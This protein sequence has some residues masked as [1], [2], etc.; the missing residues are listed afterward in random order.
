MILFMSFTQFIQAQSE[1]LKMTNGTSQVP[2]N[3]Y[4]FY[5]SGG[6]LLFTPGT[7]EADEYNWTT[8]YQHNED[9]TLT[10]TVP[11]GK[12]VKVEFSK[13][14]INND[15]LYFYEG[16]VVDEANLICI[17]TCNDYSSSLDDFS[18]ISHGNMTIRFQSDYHW[19]D[20]G[21]VATIK[22]TDEFVSQAPVAVMA[23]CANQMV[24]IPTCNADDGGTMPM[25]YKLNG[26]PWQDY[27]TTGAWVDLTGQT[28]PLTVKTRTKIDEENFSDENT[29]TFNAITAPGNPTYTHNASSNTVTTYF[30][31]KPD[32]V[33]D[34]YYVRWTINNNSNSSHTE[35]PNLWEQVGHE[36]QQP[37]NTPNTVPAGD[38]DYTNVELSLPFYIHFA[39][40]GTT[41]PENFSGVVTVRI[42]ERYVPKPTISFENSGSYGVA[43]LSCSLTDATIYYTTD[44][45]T[46][47]SSST[48][49]TS[50]FNVLPGTTVNA[51][52][53]RAG[54][55]P[56]VVASAIFIPGGEGS[57]GNG[58]Y[59]QVVLLDDRE[60]HSWSYYSDG[61]QPI[62]SLNPTD[63]KI[64]YFGDG[65]GTMTNASENQAN[66]TTFSANATGAMVNYDALANQFVYLKTLENA[67]AEGTGNYPYTMIPNP[68]QIRP[69]FN[70]KDDMGGRGQGNPQRGNRDVDIEDFEGCAVGAIPDGWCN[71]CVA[72]P[73]GQNVTANPTVS[74]GITYQNGWQTVTF[75]MGNNNKFMLLQAQ[76]GNNNNYGNAFIV[77][78][79][80]SEV[81]AIEFDYRCN[82]NQ[83]NNIRVG[84]YR[85]NEAYSDANEVHV[86]SNNDNV[87]HFSL[88]STNYPALFEII[89]NGGRIDFRLFNSGT[90]MMYAGIDNVTV[91]YVGNTPPANP[92][93]DYANGHLFEGT[94]AAITVTDQTSNVTIYYTLDGTTPNASS[95]TVTNGGTVTVDIT[96]PTLK[97]IAIRN[98]NP[99]LVSGVTTATY[100]FNLRT[101]TF[102]PDGGVIVGA[103]SQTVTITRLDDNT[104]VYYTLD[105]TD[106]TTSSPHFTSE[107]TT[108]TVD[109]SHTVLK[110]IAIHN[111]NN[112]LTSA[113]KT[114]VYS[115]KLNDPVISPNSGFYFASQTVTITQQGEGD[116]YYTTDGSVPDPTHVGGSYPTQPYTGAFTV[117]TTTT[118]KAIAY[119]DYGSSDVVEAVIAIGQTVSNNNQYRG[120][121]AWRVKR[122][123]EGLR[124]QRADGTE[125]GVGGII[126]AEDPIEFITSKEEGNEVDFEA[127]WAQAYVSVAGNGATNI[128]SQN[129]GFERNFVVLNSNSN[130]YYGGNTNPR[131]N[132]SDYAATISNYYPNGAPGNTNAGMRG[133]ITLAA[134]VK[135]ENTN[136]SCGTIT[137]NNHYLCFGRGISTNNMAAG[138]V[139]GVTLGSNTYGDLNYT[140]RMET[141][142][143][144]K[145]AFIV[146]GR[147]DNSG[148]ATFSYARGRVQVKS[149]LGSDYDRAQGDNT[150]LEVS[151]N[152]TLY[153]SRFVEITS[154]SNKDAKT[155]DCVVKSG[156]YQRDYWQG[157]NADGNSD[158]NFYC[159][160]NN[161][162]DNTYPGVRYITV[163]GGE[164]ASMNGGQGTNDNSLDNATNHASTDVVCLNVRIK[165]G[166]FNGSVFGG[167]SDNISNGG[168]S[169]VITGGT[170]KGWVAG[171]ANGTGTAANTSSMAI[172][173]GDSYIYVGGNALIG[174]TGN[175]AMVV[176]HTLG[177]Q[178]FGAG[179]GAKNGDG[180]WQRASVF[181][182]NV[183]IADNAT[184]SS[185]TQANGGSVY[186][187]GSLGVVTETANVY[188]LG[189]TIQN[190]VFGGAYG[191]GITNTAIPTS[192]IY[193]RGNNTIINGS[194][195]GGSN[196]CG[197]V[198][199]THVTMTGG[200]TTNV[201]GGGFGS[202]GTITV[203][204]GTGGTNTQNN[205][206]HNG[207]NI[208]NSTTVTVSGGTINNVYGGGEEGTVTGN[209][210]VTYSGGAVKNVYG[211]GKG[212]SSSTAQVTG[213]TYTTVN[214]GTVSECVYGGGEAGDVNNGLGNLAS[215]V[216]INGGTV[217]EDVFG[218]G[219]MG[220]TTGNVIVNVFNGNIDGNVFGGAYG[221]RE[222]V[223]IAGTHTVNMTGGNVYTNV[224]GGSRNADDALTFNPSSNQTATVNV[225]NISG[226]HVYYQVFAG[227]FFGQNYGSVYAFIGQNAIYNA[228]N[229]APTNG[230]SYNVTA[231]LIDGSVWAGADFGAFD[232]T[233]FG[234]P[235]VEGNSNVYIDGLGYNTVS[236]KPSD[237]GY[238]NI[239]TSVLGCGTSCYAGKLRNDLIFRNYGQ[240]VDNPNY[241]SESTT[242][243]YTTA[244]RNLKSIQFFKDAVIE[245][246]H[247]HFIGQGR[248]NSLLTTEKYA[249]YEISEV[250]HV[251]NGSSI[252]TD[253]PID[254]LMKLGS[255]TCPDVYVASPT[256]TKVNYNQLDPSD[257]SND[258]KFRINN[259]SLI[260]VKYTDGYGMGMPYGEFEG[261]FFVMTDDNNSVCAYARPKQ[262]TDSGNEI[263]PDYDNPDDG[264][265]LS[266]HTDKNIYDVDGGTDGE[267]IQMPYENHTL[268]SG[269]KNGEQYFR[270]WRYGGMYSYRQGVI[271]AVAKPTAGYSTSD[272]IINLPASRGTGSYFR[273]KTK[274]GGFPLIDYGSDVITVNAGVSNSSGGIGGTP[275]ANGWMYYDGDDF[276]EGQT[277]GQTNVDAGLTI[278]NANVNANF[279]LVAIP[280]GSLVGTDNGNWLICTDASDSGEAL[281][282]S[283]WSNYNETINPSILFRLT[284]NNQLTN[285]AVWDPIVI[286]L[287]QCNS[288]GTVTDE[289]EV[290]LSIS[291]TTTIEQDF[292]A[293]TFAFMDGGGTQAD[294]YVAKVV[295]PSYYQY[296]NVPGDLSDW[297]FVSAAWTPASSEFTNAWKVGSGYV[298]NPPYANNMFSMQIQPS[299]NFD[300]T[301]GWT[302]FDHTAYD[303]QTLQNNNQHPL[304]SST[305]GRNASAFD[306][307]L[308]FDGRAECNDEMLMGTL[309]VTLHLTNYKGSD[310]VNNEK[311][312]I[313]DVEVWRRGIRNIYFL[314]G[315]NGNNYFR[316]TEPNT[317]K[318]TLNGIFNHSNYK[319]GD[320]IFVV[321]TVTANGLDW[322]GELY[323][324][325]IIYRYPG[326]HPKYNSILPTEVYLDYDEYNPGNVGFTGPLLNVESSMTMHGIILDGS[327]DIAVGHPNITLVPE[328]NTY[329]VPTSPLVNIAEDATLTVYANSELRWNYSNCDGGAIYN[330][331]T[332]IINNG[333]S[334]HNNAVVSNSYNGA[335]V[336]L[337]EGATLM[338]SDLVTIN[339]NHVVVSGNDKN[340]NV[341]L[342]SESSV[343]QIGTID[344]ND[345]YG[346]LESE[347]RIGVTKG[348]WGRYYYTPIAYSDGGSDYLNNLIPADEEAP[349]G[350]YLIFDDGLYYHLVTLN[351]TETY[352]PSYNYLFWVGTWVTAVHERPS[353][354]VPGSTVNITNAEDLAWAISVV[355]GLNNQTATPNTN[356]VITDDIDMAANIWVPI[357]TNANPYTGT[358][359]AQGHNITGIHSPLN[360]ENMGVFGIVG[361]NSTVENMVVEVDFSGGSSVNMG[362]VA[363][364]VD[365][366]GSTITNVEAAGNITGSTTTEAIGGIVAVVNPSTDDENPHTIGNVFSVATM[367]ATN[368]ET[369]IGGLVGDNAADLINSYA[370]AT[371]SGSNH[372][373]GL[374]SQNKGHIENCYSVIGEQTFPAFADVNVKNE[375]FTGVIKICYTDNPYEG[376][377]VNDN[378]T[379]AV[380]EGH[381]T[382]DLI[383]ERKAY[384]Y[385]YDDNAITLESGETS[386]YIHNATIDYTDDHLINWNGLL[387]SL[388][389]WVKT[390]PD[391]SGCTPWFR[392]TSK[393]INGD[394]PILAFPS[395]NCLGTLDNDGKFLHYGSIANEANGLD[396]LLY[397]FNE[398]MNDDDASLFLYGNAT[399]VTRVPESQVKMFIN[400]DACLLQADGAGDFINTTVGI[401]FDN[402]YKAATTSNQLE[403]NQTLTYDWHFLSSPLADASIGIKYNDEAQNWWQ[404]N[405][406]TQ[407]IEVT[408]SYF[409]DGIDT[410]TV[411]LPDTTVLLGWDIYTFYEP[412]YHWINLKRNSSSHYHF[413]EPHEY[414]DYKNETIFEPGKGYMMAIETDS[415]LSNTGTLNNGNADITIP[416]TYQSHEPGITELGYNL[417]GNP[418]QAYLDMNEFLDEN[419]DLLGS[420]FWVYVA[421]NNNYVGTSSKASENKALPTST[422]HPHQAFFV[423]TNADDTATFNYKKMATVKAQPNS[424]FRGRIN[425]PLVNLFVTNEKGQKDLAVIEVNRPELGGTP[426]MRTLNNANFEFY[427]RTNGQDYSILFT[428]EGTERVAMGFKAK[429]DGTYTLTWDTQNGEFSYLQL[430]DNITGNQC[431]MLASDHYSFE[432][433]VTDLATRFYVVFKVDNNDDD[434]DDTFAFFNGNEWIINGKGTLQLIDVTGR[435]I[436]SEYLPGETS[437]RIHFDNFADGVYVL[438]LGDKTQ[439]IVIK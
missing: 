349:A 15:F 125:V 164:F 415:Y 108:V 165:D 151:T 362:G 290:A 338:V 6:P 28:F 14:L 303:L 395:D 431:D 94:S 207:T 138:I 241:S 288:D 286:I 83:Y 422:L 136:L 84:Y 326:G 159:G 400:E 426:K 227:G 32:G 322:N 406:N 137:A 68:F 256:F 302:S 148:Q 323:N 390:N 147:D 392:P 98:N 172:T 139:Q 334:I 60:D 82:G 351:N 342:Q 52:A 18:V 316:G 50:P 100:D 80:Y 127:L 327:Y 317:S 427:T 111:D 336:Y 293:Q 248:I 2:S 154:D 222:T 277:V 13:L 29:F 91:T 298:Q 146:D 278:L 397:S 385:M 124:I 437:S 346:P 54:Y 247:V 176:N 58:V 180:N 275:D 331:G 287:E 299:Y 92:V 301:L 85:D 425:Y 244:T 372:I 418:Y 280:Q 195:Y 34:T 99:E 56:S 143:Y 435:I 75:N 380:L 315:V 378:N 387:W 304:L 37:S 20:E 325:V 12:G 97:A 17:L 333:S 186:G 377:Y 260:N 179:R 432:G 376:N 173:N 47:T 270:I 19:R 231:L 330:A 74:T 109:H 319:P 73:S 404:T 123:S 233:S 78:P 69:I 221:S 433:H 144:G 305:D 120:F 39:V 46:P 276:V 412:E 403:G 420:S 361:S 61:D 89:N 314:D 251:T 163:E 152:N 4:L 434:E 297:T 354:Y 59:G 23:A 7:P 436:Y 413:D 135:F 409:P 206:N 157:N 369:H 261:F 438:R 328:S 150:L 285:N 171:G 193:I 113:V 391:Y 289:I 324:K 402:S 118:V 240:V 335:G 158:H 190:D 122:L 106:P 332:L 271:N 428:E 214:G 279:G 255:Y 204:T 340:N 264:G 40:R 116:I 399:G 201:F 394:L 311:D 272:V 310:H 188:I 22:Q 234:A 295:L 424:Y 384:G 281:T 306:F 42:D 16:N 265:F 370:N 414:I 224:Y 329:Q 189:G 10:L 320:I 184:I 132:S 140:I 167:A 421:E 308:H 230:V 408:G 318:L 114:A 268:V 153:F 88:N 266:Y 300:N 307:I 194:V 381:G 416:L 345:V 220:K 210:N 374:V 205:V 339:N 43:T 337:N 228:P 364:V 258:N 312:L 379:G 77:L 131:I 273:I 389:K 353:T 341:Y 64:T 162:N 225:V 269:S 429:E 93:F 30:P 200:T 417:L 198:T 407:V 388:N 218:G 232:G 90:N 410:V 202:S 367:T 262:S 365:G 35:N 104:T 238:M 67:D 107:T 423:Q 45:S 254:Q 149:I 168:R 70:S 57:N 215:T 181:N 439:K 358:F 63:V 191:N 216:T 355:N 121:Y 102:T 182:S 185:G 129:V 105:G 112:A 11:A 101:P 223:Y 170:I 235:T 239:G 66:P 250:L 175:D 208:G 257:H 267:G 393:I 160:P 24:L 321:N 79:E 363:A 177:G 119:T 348:D 134:D 360:S 87:N 243:P 103:T 283:Q 169:F 405:D 382:Y 296:V 411:T 55:T 373:G 294:T 72:A 117:T 356:F 141:G 65:I 155:F 343:V 53:V 196:V 21:W 142:S 199:N 38:I 183:V 383:K 401:T 242:E 396:N 51:I 386:S 110:A 313:I 217:E 115:F 81:T 192:N 375:D 352:E 252:I 309:R 368:P 359:D 49:Y 366:E 430:I 350:D 292:T 236:T 178:V 419:S 128:T 62:H 226:G 249:L 8:W 26:N 1:V 245:K 5:D 246:A 371:M 282:T 166:I 347:S 291:T 161:G 156:Q 219:K 211:A 197:T 41:C 203:Y 263:N 398:K 25:Q 95:S 31:V 209:T 253:F 259:G 130:Y 212:S 357:G 126:Y 3:G 96:H 187:G 213:Q 44:G 344:P 48:Q 76:G 9:Y 145:L 133:D 237:A 86:Y 71:N 33:N 284:Y 274:E 229:H 174:S 27:P 36:F